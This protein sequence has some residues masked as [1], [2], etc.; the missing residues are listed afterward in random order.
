MTFWAKID[1]LIQTHGDK[2]RNVLSL[3]FATHSKLGHNFGKKKNIATIIRFFSFLSL[4][5]L[6]TF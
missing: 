2:R 3:P 5:A 6:Y 1:D 4:V